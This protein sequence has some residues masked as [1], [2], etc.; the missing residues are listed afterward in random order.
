LL[1]GI[2]WVVEIRLERF[3]GGGLLHLEGVEIGD[4]SK[5]FVVVAQGTGE[6]TLGF[7]DLGE[8]GLINGEFQE[9]FAQEIDG[10]LKVCVEG[11]EAVLKFL[12]FPGVGV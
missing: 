10:A 8:I 5:G 2:G 9:A 11:F 3:L 12:G 4:E 6:S 7:G 1:V